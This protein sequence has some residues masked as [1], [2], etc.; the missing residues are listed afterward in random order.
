VDEAFRLSSGD[1]SKVHR[2]NLDLL[3]LSV[4]VSFFHEDTHVF[5]APSHNDNLSLLDQSCHLQRCGCL[6]RPQWVN[7]LSVRRLK[8][9]L[10][11]HFPIETHMNLNS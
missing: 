2:V 11:V 5:L 10:N 9:I 1:V 6:D 7:G 8:S 4:G 3:T